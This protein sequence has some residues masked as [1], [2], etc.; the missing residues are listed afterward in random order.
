MPK[1]MAELGG[2]APLEV[3]LQ[4]LDDTGRKLDQLFQDSEDRL[5]TK[6]LVGREEQFPPYYDTP[7]AAGYSM[8]SAWFKLGGRL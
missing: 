3:R 4:R 5:P 7:E 6:H 2:L 1:N 8:T